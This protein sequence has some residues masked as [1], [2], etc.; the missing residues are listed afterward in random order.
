MSYIRCNFCKKTSY[1]INPNI[2]AFLTLFDVEASTNNFRTKH[3]TPS[4]RVLYI[5]HFGVPIKSEV[6][7]YKAAKK[8]TSP[9]ILLSG[10]ECTDFFVSMIFKITKKM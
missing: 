10:T 9:K 4:D 7:D 2:I 8:C 6:G 5:A 3:F 1:D